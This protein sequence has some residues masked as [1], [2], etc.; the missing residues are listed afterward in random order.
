VKKGVIVLSLIF[1]LLSCSFDYREAQV[2][3][4]LEDTI[5]NIVLKGFRQTVV[6]KGKV[7]L[8]VQVDKAE[9]FERK[10]RT[11]FQQVRFS[12]FDEEGKLL[13]EGRADTVVYESDT[14]NATVSGKVFIH[15]LREEDEKGSW[16]EGTGFTADLKRLLV[17]FS[18]PVR[19]EYVVEKK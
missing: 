13:T 17:T 16:I 19:G 5:P 15:S 9:G 14:K 12:E 2:P 11:I 18:G 4:D 10:K 6:S 1:F 7:V 8:R 3:E